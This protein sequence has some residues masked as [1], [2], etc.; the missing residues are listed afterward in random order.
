MNQRILQI[1]NIAGFLGM[2]TV[3]V[4]ANALPINGKT[5]GQLSDQYPN[6][7]VPA[8]ITF[9]VWGLIYLLLAAFTVY[10]ARDLFAGREAGLPFLRRIGWW[11]FAS[12]ALN[13]LWIFAWHY[14][15]VALSVVIMLLLLGSLIA[16]Y[17][18]LGVGRPVESPEVKALVHVPFSVYLG[19]I[20]IAT[21]A[22][23]T[24]WLVD[25]GWDRF[26]L[27]EAF[28]TV[29]MLAVATALT[30]AVLLTRSDIFY[31]LVV[32]WAFAGILIKR[33]AEP[34]PALQP[35]V[36]SL[37]IGM[38]LIAAAAIARFTRWLA[39]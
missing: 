34:T 26:G 33:L 9:A 3:N 2:V 1:A 23:I 6:L 22:N 17:L 38:A 7:F 24:A 27:S 25:I 8:G 14:E 4:L 20:T 28:W 13:A 5:T 12:S 11:F 10:Q 35:I 29:A 30:L 19:W 16:I 18:R 32:L 31:G 39:A 15:R 36:L 37:V 21:V